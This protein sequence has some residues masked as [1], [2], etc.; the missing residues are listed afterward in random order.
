MSIPS[1]SQ[2]SP[3]I[4][5]TSIVRHDSST[6]NRLIVSPSTSIDYDSQQQ[7]SALVS[8]PQSTPK[9]CLL[10]QRL[11]SYVFDNQQ[12]NENVQTIAKNNKK[13]R[14]ATFDYSSFTNVTAL[15][16]IHNNLKSPVLFEIHNDGDDEDD[17]DDNNNIN[18]NYNHYHDRYL[19]RPPPLMVLSQTV[20]AKHPEQLIDTKLDYQFSSIKDLPNAPANHSFVFYGFTS[21]QIEEAKRLS[22]RMGDCFTS[23]AIDLTTTHVI[24]PNDDPHITITLD[25]I[26]ALIYGCR[27]VTLEWLKSSSRIG[28]WLHFNKFE[29][30]SLLNSNP[31]LNIY[32]KYRQQKKS[33]ELFNQCGLIYIT[34]IVQQRQLLLKLITLLGG[35]ITINRNRAQMIVG[36]SSKILQ[37]IVHPQVNEQWVIDSIK[38]G[39]CLPTDDYL[40]DNDNNC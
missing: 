2:S 15:N 35:N 3:I 13:Q 31:S 7:Y 18:K 1:Q 37:I 25:F 12:T 19:L 5:F 32:R 20:Q 38:M 26:L 36:Q 40:I 17:N 21:T 33:I 22:R 8:R 6:S 10:L 11:S 23:E 24:V 39:K 14:M 27:I 16:E 29:P 34:S 4:H 30:K 28:E 9:S